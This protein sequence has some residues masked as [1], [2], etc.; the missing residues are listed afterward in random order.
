MKY[1]VLFRP[2]AAVSGVFPHL[3]RLAAFRAAQAWVQASL[4]SGAIQTG[5]LLP[6]EM[7]AVI[8][9]DVE[10]PSHLT[11]VIRRCPLTPYCRVEP[12]AVGE[13]DQLVPT[14]LYRDSGALLFERIS[15]LAFDRVRAGGPE[16]AAAKAPDGDDR[17]ALSVVM[18]FFHRLGDFQRVLPLNARA[19]E[20]P[21]YEIVLA[22]DE[23]SEADAVVAFVRAHPSIRFRVLVNRTE[24][25]WRPP[26]RALNVGI[27]AAVGTYVLVVSPESAFVGDVP[28][29]ALGAIGDNPRRGVLG[30]VAFATFAQLAES[31]GAVAKAFETVSAK[32]RPTSYGSIC[33]SR[34]AL[35]AIHGYDE[36]LDRWGG[37]DDNIR[38][39]LFM[40]GVTLQLH[41]GMNLVHLSDQPRDGTRNPEQSP[42]EFP[43]DYGRRVFEPLNLVAN[44][45]GWGETFRE[46]IHDWR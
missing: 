22:L 35:H 46:V 25:G 24:H 30:H 31:D 28:A 43:E 19:L 6:A 26:C 12:V 21:S 37:D 36:S 20:N 44:P 15:S 23:P 34:G 33:A 3:M 5:Y 42:D 38:V 18:P 4:A 39:R 29:I 11:A 9:V 16:L 45:D 32:S 40:A 1:L 2:D 17:I 7:G 14:L 41:S 27:R 13:A 10:S 8:V